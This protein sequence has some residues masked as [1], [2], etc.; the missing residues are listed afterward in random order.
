MNSSNELLSEEC[1]RIANSHRQA[2]ERDPPVYKHFE[3][4]V[5]PDFPEAQRWLEQAKIDKNALDAVLNAANK[6]NK[7][8]GHV[9]F[10]AYEVAEKAL[11][12]GM[13]A[14]HGR[15]TDAYLGGHHIEPLYNNIAHKLLENSCRELKDYICVLRQGSYY[16]KTRFPNQ[17]YGLPADHFTL[18]QAH[19]AQEIA[20]YI[21][22][23]VAALIPQDYSYYA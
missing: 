4:E 20:D 7:L 16:L 6:T 14:V 9:C 18:E 17:C 23:T 12:A 21:I 5:P 10:L 8:F 13:Y 15:R 1:D 11:K 19:K 22:Q 3:E 2:T